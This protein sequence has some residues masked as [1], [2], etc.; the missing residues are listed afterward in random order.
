MKGGRRKLLANL[1]HEALDTK[2]AAARTSGNDMHA[3]EPAKLNM[4]TNSKV[5]CNL[6][7]DCMRL[8]SLF[9]C[10]GQQQSH[11]ST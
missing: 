1:A 7:L 11:S 4:L 2:M 3:P 9:K 10:L 8:R 6:L 5:D